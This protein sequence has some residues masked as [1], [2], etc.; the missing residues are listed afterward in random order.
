MFKNVRFGQPPVRF[1]APAYPV[2]V[3]DNSTVQDSS[4]GPSCIQASVQDKL[5]NAPRPPPGG[6]ESEDCLFLDVYVP[7][8][9]LEP[10]APLLPVVVYFHG[11]AYIFGS[12]DATFKDISFYDGQS[13]MDVSG[14]GLIWVVGN[15]RLGAYGFLA[16]D[17][18]EK[19][20]TPNAALHDQRLLLQW[21]RDY[22]GQVSGDKEAVT[23]WGHSAGAGS[24]LH[25]LTA[26]GGKQNPLFHQAVL[27]SPTYQWA[28]DR[29]GALE[30]TFKQ[31]VRDTDCG[32]AQ[33]GEF[34]CLRKTS[35]KTLKDANQAIVDQTYKH[36]LL[37][38]G[39]AVD[40]SWVPKLATTSL[41]QSM[42]SSSLIKS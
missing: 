7:T 8:W 24:L 31:L 41:N 30:R 11:G 5:A 40:G 3:A 14:G 27:L 16:G 6:E 29:S 17:T 1:G 34:E 23:A 4:Y 36:G 42:Y 20:G 38:F 12:K 33:G 28:S 21:V 19:L 22:I 35:N 37:P 18:M 39:P 2:A 10:D 32:A 26:Y 13:V 15:Y 25:H 9:V